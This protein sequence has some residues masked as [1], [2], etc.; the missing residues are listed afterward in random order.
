MTGFR[1]PAGG[2]AR[3]ALALC[4]LAGGT[5]ASVVAAPVEPGE[6]A[7]SAANLDAAAWLAG[8]WRLEQGD[9]RIDEQWMEP[10]GGAMVGMSRTVQAG[11]LTGF[12]LV[13]IDLDEGRLTYRAA[14]SGQAPAAFPL[15]E[16][17]PERL[18]FENPDH[19]FPQRIGYQR[20]KGAAMAWI[21]GGTGPSLRRREFPYRRVACPGGAPSR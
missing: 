7:G 14:P 10:A 20:A 19:D 12:E 5:V 4:T 2:L 17:T 9:L 16:A 6:G 18:V 13:R 1:R 3:A 21:E 8:C 11:R 15:R